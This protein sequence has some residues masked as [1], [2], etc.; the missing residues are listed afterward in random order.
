VN[1]DKEVMPLLPHK[2]LY[3]DEKKKE[4]EQSAGTGVYL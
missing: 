3:L 2:A 4:E 1:L